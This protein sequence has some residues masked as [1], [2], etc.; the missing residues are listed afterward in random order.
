MTPQEIFEYKQRWRANAQGVPIHSDYDWRAKT[1]CRKHLERHQWSMDTYTDVY[2]HTV[3]FE[4]QHHAQ[5]FTQEYIND[6]TQ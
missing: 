3:L 4:H 1:W 6:F 5:Q 2:E